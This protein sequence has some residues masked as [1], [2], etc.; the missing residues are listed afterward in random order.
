MNDKLNARVIHSLI[1]FPIDQI[2]VYDQLPST[3]EEAQTEVWQRPGM[4]IANE[5]TKGK[6]QNGHHFYS[7][8]NNGVYF[9]VVFP[10]KNEFVQNPGILTLGIGVA[11]TQA[12]NQ[13]Y[14]IDSQLKWVNDI[15]Y[16][17]SKVGGILTEIQSNENNQPENFIMGI[18]LDIGIMPFSRN[19]DQM[20]GSLNVIPPL[21]RNQVIAAIYN[22]LYAIYYEWTADQIIVEYVKHLMWLNDW[23]SLIN[24]GREM[25]GQLVGINDKGHLLLK[26]SDDQMMSLDP[27][28]TQNI[29]K[30]E[31]GS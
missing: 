8:A 20:V 21:Q 31:S 25:S 26:T 1:S 12:I 22:H 11:V 16:D 4:I 24:Q 28:E 3:N 15:Y 10:A 29:R 30:K 23:V 13:V 17:D 5:Q 6:G 9:T 7:P 19:E 14:R 2:E 18:G 27:N